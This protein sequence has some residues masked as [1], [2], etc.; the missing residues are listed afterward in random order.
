M[1]FYFDHNVPRSLSEGLRYKGIEVVTAFKDGHHEVPYRNLL[2]RATA[3]QLPLFTMD[4]DLLVEA[5]TRQAQGI[6]F[7]GVIYQHQL[8]AQ[9]GQCVEDLA[10]EEAFLPL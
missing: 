4:D 2:E 7:S 5:A 10:N 1:K 6:P 9:I 3:L 8:K